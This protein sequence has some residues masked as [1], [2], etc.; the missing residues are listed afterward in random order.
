MIAAPKVLVSL[1]ENPAE[2]ATPPNVPVPVKKV[3]D[4]PFA[5]IGIVPVVDAVTATNVCVEVDAVDAGS[6]PIIAT[7]PR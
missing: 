7:C 1:S 2:T 6:V 3:I 5:P 4:Q